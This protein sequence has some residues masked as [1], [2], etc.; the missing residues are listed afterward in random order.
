MMYMMK[1]KPPLFCSIYKRDLVRSAR[2]LAAQELIDGTSHS[3]GQLVSQLMYR[4]PV[5]V[6]PPINIETHIGDKHIEWL[7]SIQ[8]L[9]IK[10]N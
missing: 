3:T 4:E 9:S 7:S 8:R 10:K 6:E 2:S 1:G 5:T